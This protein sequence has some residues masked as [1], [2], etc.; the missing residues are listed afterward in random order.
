MCPQPCD[1]PTPRRASLST[2]KK[3][4]HYRDKR[5]C[6]WHTMQN[7]WYVVHRR[8]WPFVWY[9]LERTSEI[10]WKISDIKFTRAN[11]KA[12]TS[13]KHKSTITDHIAQENHVID[14]EGATILDRDSNSATRK[15]REAIHISKR[16]AKAINRD[17]GNMFLDHVYDLLLKPTFNQR[18]ENNTERRGKRSGPDHLWSN[19]QPRWRKLKSWVISWICQRDLFNI[20]IL[21]VKFESKSSFS[22]MWHILLWLSDTHHISFLLNQFSFQ[23]LRGFLPQNHLALLKDRFLKK[24]LLNRGKNTSFFFVNL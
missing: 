6:L 16:R 7:L 8:D 11:R 4:G 17:D 9:P 23:I 10:F 19:H 18:S 24:M 5:C 20:I 13:E 14:W 12:S 3:K 21:H 1:L 2:R 22:H 15:I